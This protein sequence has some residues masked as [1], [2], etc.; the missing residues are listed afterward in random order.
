M[1]MA[2]TIKVLANDDRIRLRESDFKVSEVI[3][4]CNGLSYVLLLLL[5]LDNYYYIVYCGVHAQ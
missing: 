2:A 1:I 3:P 4:L 5:L